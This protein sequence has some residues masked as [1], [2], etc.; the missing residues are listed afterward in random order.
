VPPVSK[1][2]RRKPRRS[3]VKRLKKR[4]V[5]KPDG[6]YLIYFEKG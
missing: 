4:V 6:R 1:A 3:A 5:R 2:I